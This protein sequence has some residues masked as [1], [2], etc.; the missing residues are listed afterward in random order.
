MYTSRDSGKRREKR[1]QTES[2]CMLLL[3][4]LLLLLLNEQLS[5][6]SGGGGDPRRS[7]ARN[8][9]QRQRRQLPICLRHLPGKETQ[10][11]AAA[12][13]AAIAAAAV[14]AAA[15]EWRDISPGSCCRCGQ[16]ER[17]CLFRVSGKRRRSKQ[18]SLPVLMP[19][20]MG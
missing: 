20:S 14:A 7:L 16:G 13:P 8:G 12:V 3:L 10:R 18:R 15:A 2:D 19:C 6:F 5:D 4:L 17:L 9:W 11:P 1:E